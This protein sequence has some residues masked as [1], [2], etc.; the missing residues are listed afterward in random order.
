MR[1]RVHLACCCALL[2]LAATCALAPAARAAPPAPFGHACSPLD[3]ALACPTAD[4][5]ARVASFDGVPLDVDV[6][7]PATGDG[8]FPTIALLHGF[9]QSKTALESAGADPSYNAS[10]F[11]RAGYAVVVPTARGFGRSC[12]VADSRTAGCERGWTHVGDQRYEARDVQWLLGLLVDQGVARPDALGVTGVSYGGGTSLQL[13]VLGDRVRLPDGT[14]APWSSP[15]GTPLAIAAAW[16]RWPWSDLADALV[17]NGRL[18]PRSYAS[19]IGVELQAY[20]GVLTGLGSAGGFLAPPG[21]DPGADIASWAQGLERGEPYGTDVAAALGELHAFHG[22]LNIPIER[23]ITPL[24]IQAGWTDDLF[25]VGQTLR[26]YDLLRGVDRN[27]VVQLQLGDLGHARGANHPDDVRAFDAQGLAFLG[28]RL[29]GA[30]Q[31]AAANAAPGAVT[32][33]RQTCPRTAPSGGPAIVASSFAGL[34]RGSLVFRHRAAQRVISSGGDAALSQRLSPLTLDPCLSFPV[35]IAR[36]TAIA[37]VRSRGFTLL[38]RTRVRADVAVR[39]RD[40]LVVGRLWD[41]DPARGRQRLVDRGVVRLRSKRTLSFNLNGNA[42][43]FAPGHHVE[44]ELVG[45]DAPTYRAAND[46][47]SVTT[48]NLTVTLPTRERRPGR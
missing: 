36:G 7:L 28:R 12:G 48:R 37:T 25:P 38:G 42:Y 1:P 35:D 30:A 22:A 5:A 4:D 39:G 32:A 21:V 40:A 24:L 14:T 34:A 3:G 17:P 13:A 11:A 16:P 19:P 41:V 26:I 20:T 18:G 46:D 33:L 29:S 43:R 9:G 6:W 45:R 47:F 2:A 23:P 27:A 44:L 15:A 10:A 31:P 8:P